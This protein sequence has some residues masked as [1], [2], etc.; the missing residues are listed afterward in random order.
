[1]VV[2]HA[3]FEPIRKIQDTNLICP[4]VISQW[5]AVGALEAGRPYANAHRPAMAAARQAVLEALQDAGD[6]C[7]VPTAQGAF[8]LLLNVPP[9]MDSMRLVE[10]LVRE[11]RVAVMPGSTFGVTDRCALRVSYG[12]LQSET[13]QEG[14]GRLIAG[15]RAILGK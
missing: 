7:S 4:P 1:M 2:P 15:L 3:L 9:A 8:Y 6:V 10:R 11:Y 12:P 14:I 13:A 5:A